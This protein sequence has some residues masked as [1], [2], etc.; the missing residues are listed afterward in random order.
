M[1]GGCPGLKAQ[2]VHHRRPRKGIAARL[3]EGA[4]AAHPQPTAA[5]S[6]AKPSRRGLGVEHDAS[7]ALRTGRR[8]AASTRMPQTRK[9]RGATWLLRSVLL[10]RG[11][12]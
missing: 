9:K 8:V 5:A 2:V 11:A 3:H 7:V 6:E 4:A 12:D 10:A 1:A